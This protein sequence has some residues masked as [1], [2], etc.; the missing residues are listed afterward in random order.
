MHDGA[1]G[2]GDG[3]EGAHDQRLAR[4]RDHLRDDVGR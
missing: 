2:A 3:L 1:L 4:L